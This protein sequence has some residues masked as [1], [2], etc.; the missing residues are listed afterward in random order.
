MKT[1][2][3]NIIVFT[4]AAVLILLI[5]WI[6]Y[7]NTDLEINKF[8]IKSENIPAEFDN[9]RIVQ[10]SDLHNSEFDKNNEKLIEM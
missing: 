3:K 5:I 7:G 6:A 10:V 8:N 9:F 2:K 4:V 1:K